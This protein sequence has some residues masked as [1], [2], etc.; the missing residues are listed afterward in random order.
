MSGDEREAGT[1]FLSHNI[2]LLSSLTAKKTLTSAD[3]CPEVLT[4]TWLCRMD[5]SS[6]FHYLQKKTR[7]GDEGMWGTYFYLTIS[8]FFSLQQMHEDQLW[9]Y[10]RNTLLDI[11]FAG[12]SYGVAWH[13]IGEK[14]R[15][16]PRR[17]DTSSWFTAALSM[18][19]NDVISVVD[20]NSITR[21]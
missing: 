15:L 16:T 18:L 19:Q 20:D 9:E 12:L 3:K 7:S 5:T 4:P 8:C 17:I 6:Y 14:E 10:C 2:T 21:E 11:N 13:C 1:H